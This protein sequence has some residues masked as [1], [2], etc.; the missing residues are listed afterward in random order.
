LF[1]LELLGGANG[2]NPA[3]WWM[4]L[5]KLGGA[6]MLAQAAIDLK[7]FCS[8]FSQHLMVAA[9]VGFGDKCAE[10]ALTAFEVAMR[11]GVEGIF[12]LLGHGLGV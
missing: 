5:G 2:Y 11:E 8:E 9:A 7:L 1:D 4:F 6:L 3:T 10:L 12:D